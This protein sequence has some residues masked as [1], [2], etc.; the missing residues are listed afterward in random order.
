M[1]GP[2][3]TALGMKRE[4]VKRQEV[5]FKRKR[6]AAWQQRMEGSVTEKRFYQDNSLSQPRQ[7]SL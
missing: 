5:D 1:V 3:Y 4:F 7:S 6:R 2:G